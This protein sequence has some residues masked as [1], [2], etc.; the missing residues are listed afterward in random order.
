ML[1]LQ[2]KQGCST[3][4]V[5]TRANVETWTQSYKTY[6]ILSVILQETVKPYKEKSFFL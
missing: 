3:N 2:P 5:F 1:M 6:I 4:S